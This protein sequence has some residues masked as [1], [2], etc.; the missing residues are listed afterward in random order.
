AA[1]A[2]WFDHLE[3]SWTNPDYE[4]P[5]SETGRA[6]QRRAL[7]V[8]DLLRAHYRAAGGVLVSPTETLIP[9]MLQAFGPGVDF[10]FHLAMPLP[11][12]YHL[13]HDGIGWRVMGGQ[14]FVEAAAVN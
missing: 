7:R 12:L 5:G 10:T 8:L 1:R 9:R 2:E 4:P 14:G 6:A 13:E 11:A 3:R